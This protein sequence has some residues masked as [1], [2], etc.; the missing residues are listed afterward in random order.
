[1]YLVSHFSALGLAAAVIAVSVLVS[2]GCL[3]LVRR[4]AA[5]LHF[6]DATQFGEIFSASTGMIIALIFAF[7]TMAAWGNY[8]KVDGIVSRE[9]H[10]LHNIHRN[11]ESYPQRIS[12][13]VRAIMH[14]YVIQVINHEWQTTAEGKSDEAATQMLYKFGAMLTAYRIVDIGEIPLHSETLRLIAEHRSLTRDRIKGGEPCLEPPM[15]IALICG[16]LIFIAYSC[17]FVVP[18]FRN[19]VIMISVLGTALGLMFYL[20]LVYNYPFTGP[21]AIGSEPYRQ[22]LTYWK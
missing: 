5:R 19:H 3:C 2:I 13:P 15:W 16:A 11:L 20:L 7:V 8:D 9:A 12:E 1:M 21:A 17:F 10:V 18:R 22:L 14:D 6:V 4:F